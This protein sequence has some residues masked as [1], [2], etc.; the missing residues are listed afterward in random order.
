MEG[1]TDKQQ[2]ILLMI[3]SVLI[4]VSGISAAE[5]APWY[6]TTVLA[7]LGAIGFG[8]KEVLGGKSS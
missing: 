8:L 4:A 3:A 7:I 5:G 1:L 2:A 6:V